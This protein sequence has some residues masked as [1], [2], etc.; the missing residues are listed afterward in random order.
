MSG[1]VKREQARRDGVGGV[2]VGMLFQNMFQ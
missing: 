2:G 1:V